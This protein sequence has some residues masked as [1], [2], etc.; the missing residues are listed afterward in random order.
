MIELQ[1]ISWA[2]EKKISNSFFG[3]TSG[4]DSNVM[5]S[6]IFFLKSPR[7]ACLHVDGE[8]SA[9]RRIPPIYCPRSKHGKSPLMGIV[10]G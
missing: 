8:D 4:Q 6:S 5:K 9:N 3:T 10:I 1:M 2:E 7:L